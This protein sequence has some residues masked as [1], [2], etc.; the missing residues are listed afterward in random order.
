MP[1]SYLKKYSEIF[2]LVFND[3][4]VYNTEGELVLYLKDNRVVTYKDERNEWLRS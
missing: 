2:D 3:G 4:K 1:E